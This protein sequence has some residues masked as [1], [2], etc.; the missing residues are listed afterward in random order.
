MIFIFR[1]KKLYFICLNYDEAE[2]QIFHVE[3]LISIKKIKTI[4]FENSQ[5]STLQ[6]I[7][8]LIILHNFE[9]C[10]SILIDLKS[11]SQ[12]KVICKQF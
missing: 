5:I 4:L 12:D 1:Y 3:S 2:I 11:E 10:D 9:R 6:F 8:N 7:D